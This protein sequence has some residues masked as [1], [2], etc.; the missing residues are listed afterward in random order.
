MNRAVLKKCLI[1]V[2]L[3]WGACAICL[4]LFCW[5]RVFIVSRMQTESFA[6]IIDQLWDT[7]KDF[8]PVPLSQLLSYSGRVAITF[9]EPI[10]I[11]CMAVFSISRGSD[12]VSGEL[13][14]GTM[15]MLLAQPVSRLSIL[16]TQ[17]LVTT[18]GLATLSLI[19]WLGI[20]TGIHSFSVKEQAQPRS[21][22][23]PLVGWKIPITF[24]KP[25]LVDVP[26]GERVSEQDFLPGALNYFSLGF[27]LAGIATLFSSMDRFRWRTIGI[28]VSFYVISL[29]FKITGLALADYRWMKWL[30]IFTPYEP[31]R[32]VHFAVN[33][34]ER[35]WSIFLWN[36]K[37]TAIESLGPMGCNLMLLGVGL[38]AYLAAGW[39]FSRRDLPAPM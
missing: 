10:V 25:E 33:H 8:A 26:M 4:F 1:E 2:R 23:L 29:I 39:I 5:I 11:L 27:C 3:L 7:W 20:Y 32:F 36:E 38:V 30:S 24:A 6:A 12:A 17:A 35:A 31:Q 18:L 37:Q 22:N 15:E 34:P 21:I 16:Y 28:M 19:I 13:N 9:D 14:R